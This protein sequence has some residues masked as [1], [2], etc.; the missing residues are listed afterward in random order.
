VRADLDGSRIVVTGASSGIGREIAVQ[1]APRARAVALVARRRERLDR[2]AAEL[3]ELHPRLE[4]H[5]FPCDLAD[6]EAA[7]ALASALLAA[8]G[9]VDVLVNDAGF[10]CLGVFD[11]ADLDAQ[12]RMIDVNVTSVVVLTR[13]LLPGMVARR[14][15]AILN[16]SSGFGLSFAPG[17]AV[18]VGTKH[19][20]TGFSESLRLDLGGT[21]VV[22]T[23]VCPGPVAT[24]FEEVAGNFTGHEVPYAVQITAAHCARDAIAGLERGRALVV[25][26]LVP[27]IGMALLAWTPR[28]LQRLALARGGPWLR[29]KE[30][31]ADAGA[32]HGA[33]SGSRA[34]LP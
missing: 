6:R 16:V 26:G 21:R 25:P 7:R 18:Y 12:T 33:P 27:R 2:L 29:A 8:L 30:Q 1:L 10:G 15:G 17:F 28:V 11:R 23:Q 3:R 34:G 20:V 9:E 32:L 5:V 13:A 14:R 24:E 31:E 22:V 4:V 19:F